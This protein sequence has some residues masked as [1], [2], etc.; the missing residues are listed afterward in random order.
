M[1]PWTSDG[2]DRGHDVP[3]PEHLGEDYIVLTGQDEIP[4]ELLRTLAS[5]HH[6]RQCAGPPNVECPAV[7]GRQC[8][9]RKDAR[10]AIVFLAGEHE[11][12]LSGRWQC[13][14]AGR[15][16]AVVVLEGAGRTTE[17]RHGFAVVGAGNTAGIVGALSALEGEE[18]AQL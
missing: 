14:T 17:P 2:P 18:Q 3:S 8:A 7:R 1:R 15:S 9:L 11:F 10:A 12:F 6:L 4:P 5:D 13:V 16:P